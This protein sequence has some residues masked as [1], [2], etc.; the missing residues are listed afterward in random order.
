MTPEKEKNVPSQPVEMNKLKISDSQFVIRHS[1]I[2]YDNAEDQLTKFI[3]ENITYD[4]KKY[5]IELFKSF[6][7][8]LVPITEKPQ[9]DSF[10]N[11][12]G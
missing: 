8:N 11:D 6:L 7:I 4:T 1:Q 5:Q 3:E 2:N 9:A 12:M 10:T